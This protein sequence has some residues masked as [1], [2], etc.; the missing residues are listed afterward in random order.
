MLIS[1]NPYP[2]VVID[3]GIASLIL[4]LPFAA[5]YQLHEKRCDVDQICPAIN[6]LLVALSRRDHVPF[7][8]GRH[9]V[10]LVIYG[11]VSQ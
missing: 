11:F 3:I 1:E 8:A 2:W 7:L 9:L 10:E 4:P 6:H 5:F